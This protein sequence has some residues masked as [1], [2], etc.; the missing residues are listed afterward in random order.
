MPILP[1]FLNGQMRSITLRPVSKTSTS[2]DC[3]SNAGADP[4]DREADVGRDRALAVDRMTEDVEDAPSVDSPTGTVIGRPCRGRDAAGETVGR[5]H[6]HGP[7]PVVAEVLL[8]LADRRLQP[9]RS[10][11]TAL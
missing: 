11:S 9:A 4:M 5:G 6:G 3:W 7:D 10:I 1:P 2:V 8:D